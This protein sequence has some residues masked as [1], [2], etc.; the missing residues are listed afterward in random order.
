MQST[1]QHPRPSR[2]RRERSTVGEVTLAWVAILTLV[3]AVLTSLLSLKLT[4]DALADTEKQLAIG[5]Q[6]EDRASRAETQRIANEVYL[7]EA[8]PVDYAKY[9]KVPGAVLAA[10]VNASSTQVENVWVKGQDGTVVR[11]SGLQGCT[12]YGFPDGWHPQ[13]LYFSDPYGYWH[14]TYGQAVQRLTS[15]AN[16]PPAGPVRSTWNDLVPECSP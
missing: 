16:M 15:L 9:S 4:R 14:R 3:A 11:I 10:V 7:G 5:Q 1:Q 13:E 6:A 12:M 2:P 8:P